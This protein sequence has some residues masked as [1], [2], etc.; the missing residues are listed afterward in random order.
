MHLACVR[1]SCG[2]RVGRLVGR[3]GQGRAGRDD[4]SVYRPGFGRMGSA[5]RRVRCS[6]WIGWP[7]PIELTAVGRVESA[8]FDQVDL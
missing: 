1:T 7:L 3:L 5:F 8:D 4:P 6:S 2:W